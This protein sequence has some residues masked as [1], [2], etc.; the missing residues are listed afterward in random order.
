MLDLQ[1][2][3]GI[4]LLSLLW[5]T[6]LSLPYPNDQ[7]SFTDRKLPV[8]R[9]I[10]AANYNVAFFWCILD[11]YNFPSLIITYGYIFCADVQVPWLCFE[12]I[13]QYLQCLS[14]FPI[15]VSYH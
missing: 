4:H 11:C 1:I 14:G 10:V 15:R 13:L 7:L 6:I 5:G 2:D 8:S 3:L 12:G 9:R